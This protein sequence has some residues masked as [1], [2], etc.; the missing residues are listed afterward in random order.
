MGVNLSQ[1][2]VPSRLSMTPRV[3]GQAGHRP[4]GGNLSIVTEMIRGNIR[5]FTTPF[6]AMDPFP[7]DACGRLQG[8][9]VAALSRKSKATIGGASPFSQPGDQH[10]HD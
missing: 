9:R 2:R 5:S 3:Q 8:E 1:S 4:S 7:H 6:I 10:S